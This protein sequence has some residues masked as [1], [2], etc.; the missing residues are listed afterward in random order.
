MSSNFA[1]WLRS[2]KWGFP[3]RNPPTSLAYITGFCFAIVKTPDRLF[4]E[5]VLQLLICK[6]GIA[7][8]NCYLLHIL[9]DFT[10]YLAHKILQNNLQSAG[11]RLLSP[12]QPEYN[13]YIYIYTISSDSFLL[14]QSQLL[15]NLT[16]EPVLFRA[17]F[18]GI[19]SWEPATQH[20]GSLTWK[21][22]LLDACELDENCAWEVIWESGFST[23]KNWIS[24]LV[25]WLSKSIAN[26]LCNPNNLDAF[27][28]QCVYYVHT[29][30]STYNI[31]YICIYIYIYVRIYCLYTQ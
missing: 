14:P 27:T 28:W 1:S 19:L 18:L 16:L 13:C 7:F 6:S 8:E 3:A 22:F 24:Y 5:P 12:V 29:N 26:Q 25:S 23:L 4:S 9:S 10:L 15:R 17:T 11:W 20:L 31:Y 21:I 30:T 2:W